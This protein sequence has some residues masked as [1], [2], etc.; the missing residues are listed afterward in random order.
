ML[1]YQY[2]KSLWSQIKPKAKQKQPDGSPASSNQDYKFAKANFGGQ[3]PAS[4]LN[5]EG[6]A[7]SQQSFNKLSCKE[8]NPT[9][10]PKMISKDG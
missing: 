1:E 8:E 9:S 2:M 4:R 5:T 10:N 6:T 7:S 3:T